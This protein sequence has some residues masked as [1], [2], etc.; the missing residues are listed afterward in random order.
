MR[1]VPASSLS[2][3]MRTNPERTEWAA[4]G[5]S[6]SSAGARVTVTV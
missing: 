2:L 3:T 5:T 4:L 1:T 6:T